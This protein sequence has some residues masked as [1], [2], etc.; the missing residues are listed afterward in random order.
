MYNLVPALPQQIL[1][2]ETIAFQA[3][4]SLNVLNEAY[5]INSYQQLTKI[6][7]DDRLKM[8]SSSIGK[9]IVRARGSAKL[10]FKLPTE[11]AYILEINEDT[12]VTVISQP[13]YVG[14]AYPLL[15]DY[16][17]LKLQSLMDKSDLVL[18]YEQYLKSLYPRQDLK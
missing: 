6:Y 14:S 4:F 5:T 8:L 16:L 13:I 17:D 10:S 1:P 11:G 18:V 2:N 7:F 3:N 9:G 15:P 12:G